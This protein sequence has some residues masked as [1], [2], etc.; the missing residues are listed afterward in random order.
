ME[1]LSIIKW[2]HIVIVCLVGIL[3][4]FI[5]TRNS[6]PKNALVN[7]EN[8]APKNNQDNNIKEEQNVNNE[9]VL[10]YAMWCGYSRAFLPEWEKFE[11]YA[12]SNLPNLKV[13]G[14]R[15]EDGNEATCSQKG[16]EGYPTV[17]LY[18]KNGKE[19]T[20][21]GERNMDALIKFVKENVN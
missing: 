19:I 10:Y 16:V 15:C 8:F 1:L 17:I 21:S 7:N 6:C 14:V 5:F 12:K 9:L 18:L 4:F 20:F 2:Y 11:G 3:L 13:S